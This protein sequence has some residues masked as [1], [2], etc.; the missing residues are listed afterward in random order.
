MRKVMLSGVAL[1]VV[2]TLA[3]CGGGGG[4]NNNTPMVTVSPA[5]ANLQEGS[6][7]QFAATVT[8]SSSGVNWLV[9][10]VAGGNSSS[11]TISS[12]GLYTAPVVIP[13]PASITITAQL[14]SSSTVSS[15]AVV[16]ITAVQFSNASLKGNYVF[17]LKGID[18]SG[19]A[20]Y[21]VGTVTADG[22][23][24]ITG[25]EEDLND[26]GSGY[27]TTTSVTGTY[28]VGADGRGGL[29]L[30]SS[31]GS[32]AYAFAM[33]GLTN[34]GLNEIDNNVIN[35][36]G[37]LEQ[38][39]SG[40]TAPSGNYAFG[41]SGSGL[42]CVSISSAGVF[43][44]SG[45]T[46]GGTQ[47]VNCSGNIAQSQSLTGTYSA[48]DALG[49]GTG[50]FSA[51]TGTSSFI[52]YV[53]S[54]SHYR[55]ICPD[56]ATF[57]LG[58]A[59]LQTQ[60]TFAVTDFNGNY[61]ISTSANTVAGISNTVMQLNAS[62]GSISTGYY[63]VNDTGVVGTSSLTGAYSVASNG[64]VSGSFTV[65]NFPLPFTMYMIS[66]S[67]AYYLDLRANAVG[68]GNVYAQSS[69]VTTNAAWAGSYATLQFGYFVVSGV[70]TPSNSTSISGQISADG[71][72]T[73]AG[74]LDINDP[75]SVFTAVN[76]QGTYSVGT[77]APGR[78]TVAITTTTEGT[79]NYIAYIVSP[80]QVQ[81]LEV[82]S[83]LTS[84]GDAIRQ[85]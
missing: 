47:D 46:V 72:G 70:I 10:G 31:I 66:P 61:V 80:T 67:Q 64:R 84:G 73:L 4:G 28:A 2:V 19:F 54:P 6:T 62:G 38:Q 44:L 50:S 11:G 12:S 20:F 77:V 65:S 36:V 43:D 39:T 8:N 69:A 49:R 59:D 34:A 60:P 9:N 25:G 7:L 85:F 32:F 48:I 18:A 83:N 53:V 57:F 42:G 76:L 71:N 17:S 40:V 30:T 51:A 15:N 16:T 78:T 81:L 1:A 23:G 14:Q 24:N 35:A 52:Y 74:T 26:V 3:A 29:T 55:F 58:S 82:D 56:A 41:F 5:T 45:T 22:N 79:R 37:N 21:A 75:S 13:S 68:S 27:F 63:D 33:R